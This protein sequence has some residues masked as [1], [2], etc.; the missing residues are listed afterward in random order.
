MQAQARRGN[1]HSGPGVCVPRLPTCTACS[2]LAPQSNILQPTAS[3]KADVLCSPSCCFFLIEAITKGGAG[4]RSRASPP[5]TPAAPHGVRAQGPSSRPASLSQGC[6]VPVQAPA[7]SLSAGFTGRAPVSREDLTQGRDRRTRPGTTGIHHALGAHA[8]TE[9]GPLPGRKP[10][11]GADR[12]A[13]PFLLGQQQKRGSAL[14][15]G[16]CWDDQ[17]P[18]TRLMGSHPCPEP[19]SSLC[20]MGDRLLARG[21]DP[22]LCHALWTT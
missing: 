15:P 17:V 21:T 20:A 12:P 6:S 3:Q 13:Q 16:G 8:G 5:G 14:P 18:T 4:R 2:S 9:T 22:R 19:P 1:T 11:D 7:G 10:K